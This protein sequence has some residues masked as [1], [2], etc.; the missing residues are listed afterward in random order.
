MAKRGEE[1]KRVSLGE[2]TKGVPG[3][4]VT[5]KKKREIE[6]NPFWSLFAQKKWKKRLLY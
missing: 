5:Q 3:Q 4:K 1:K 2:C 6:E